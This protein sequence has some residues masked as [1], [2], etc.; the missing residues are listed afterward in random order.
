LPISAA[1]DYTDCSQQ[2]ISPDCTHFTFAPGSVFERKP[3]NI[4]TTR[5]YPTYEN[6]KP[7]STQYMFI[8]ILQNLTFRN[9]FQFPFHSSNLF[10]LRP[11]IFLVCFK[12]KNAKSL[13]FGVCNNC[14]SGETACI[15][16]KCDKDQCCG[17]EQVGY[18][19]AD[20]VD[21]CKDYC[22]KNST[23]CKWYSFYKELQVCILTGGDCDPAT[24]D[25]SAF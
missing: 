4:L 11:F 14:V 18:V 10:Y 12:Y 16:L 19:D 9:R 25:V 17:E 5:C 13:E 20:T 3:G 21:Q 24:G 15:D 8:T 6:E 1:N 7:N 23:D 22:N 2:C